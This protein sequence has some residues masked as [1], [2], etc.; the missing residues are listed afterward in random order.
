MAIIQVGYESIQ[1]AQQRAAAESSGAGAGSTTLGSAGQR[2]AIATTPGAP[3][4][5]L[6]SV[7]LKFRSN[8][9][10]TIETCADHEASG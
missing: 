1:P 3:T 9:P 10:V 2:I 8:R 4:A 7:V 6:V 5:P